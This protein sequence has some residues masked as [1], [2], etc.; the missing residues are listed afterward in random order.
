M[1]TK[2][3]AMT[4]FLAADLA[5]GPASAEFHRGYVAVVGSS[6]VMPYAEAVGERVVKHKK[7][8]AP[9]LQST[10]TGGGVKLFCEGLNVESPDIVNASRAMKPKEKEECRRHGIADILEL[11]IGYDGLVLA[12]AQ[13][14]PPLKLSRKE[15]R[16]ALAKWIADESGNPVPNP[17]KT[18][19]SINPALPDSRIEILGPPV[20]SGTYDAFADLIAERECKGMPWVAPGQTEPTAGMLKKCR[21]LR[22]DGAYVSGRE[23]DENHVFRLA[24][25]PS[26]VAILGHKLVSENAKKLR[27]VP[28][29][30]VE[31]SYENIASKA[32]AGA[33]PLFVYV[34]KD[35]IGTVP[36]LKEFIGE[37][38]SDR[39]WGDKGY[40]KSLGLIT[41]PPGERAIY[42]AEVKNLGITPA[43]GADDEGAAKPSAK[44]SSKATKAATK[45][46]SDH[47][48]K[49]KKK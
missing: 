18:W 42:T 39:A 47:A 41:L 38:T 30:G 49:E 44:K 48:A 21:A 7:I 40:L 12:Q 3:I 45:K 1:R 27:A 32:Y 4:I 23:N 19:K 31:P 36:G 33:R 17:H 34:K 8:H 2:L 14:A 20:A 22:D 10:G 35:Q 46:T 29:D 16:L 28:I 13:E 15:V 26:A 24:S 5:A 6:A 37:F 11:K 25:S 9:L 43:T